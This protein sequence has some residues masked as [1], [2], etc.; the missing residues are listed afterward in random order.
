MASNQVQ[1]YKTDHSGEGTD[2]DEGWNGVGN[3]NLQVSQYT[4]ATVMQFLDHEAN[5]F[6]TRAAGDVNLMVGSAFMLQHGSTEKITIAAGNSGS[7]ALA[8]ALTPKVVES[9]LHEVKLI[10]TA[11]EKEE[12]NV[13]FA[14]R[15]EATN[16]YEIGRD[17]AKFSMGTAKCAQMMIPA[18][19]TNLCAADFPLVNDK[20][21]YP[22]TITTPAVGDYRIELAEAYEDATIYLTY[23][24]RV[25]WNLS[26]SPYEV[27]LQQG[28]TGG[29]GLRLVA[30]PK[31]PTDIENTEVLNGANGVQKVIIDEH[32]YILR[33]EQLF[34]VTGK[35]TR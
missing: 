11:T 15:E 33:G 10:N 35:A 16:S 18:Y 20:A 17:V 13:F 3:P 26:M 28:Q 4:S 31:N 14:A 19:G 12:D 32:V 24:G 1:V 21:S 8:P 7:I 22:L 34:D 23:E 9:V 30:A 5:A 29:Y 25:I 2:F 6:K 27:E